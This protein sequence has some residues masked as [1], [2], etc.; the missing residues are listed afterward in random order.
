MAHAVAAAMSEASRAWF[1]EETPSHT[2]SAVHPSPI[3]TA[4][5][6]SFCARFIPRSDRNAARERSGTDGTASSLA[7][8]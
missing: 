8:A 7:T 6:S 2:T 5:E 4:A 1:E 3:S